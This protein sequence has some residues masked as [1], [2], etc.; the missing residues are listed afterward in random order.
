MISKSGKM[1]DDLE[2]YYSNLLEDLRV[3]LTG[4][5]P[6]D[7]NENAAI[8]FLDQNEF[9]GEK[10]SFWKK[11]VRYV[12]L[13]EATPRGLAE[14]IAL[15]GDEKTTEDETKQ[16]QELIDK[17]LLGDAELMKQMLL[18]DGAAAHDPN[19]QK[20][21]PSAQYGH[22]MEIYS[23]ILSMQN[24]KALETGY[25]YLQRL[26]LA[27]ALE[28]AIPVTQS[29][30][31]SNES[32]Y[33]RYVDPVRRYLNYEMA[34]LNGE[35]DPCSQWLTTWELRFVVD[36]D[37]P[38]E[39]AI[40]GRK[41]LK[42]FRPDHILMEN[43]A[44]RY[45]DLVKTDVKYGSENVKND[46]PELQ[47]YQNILMNGG[48]CGRRAFMGRFILRS[49][50]I[51][52]TARP[53]KGHGALIHWIPL[54]SKGDNGWTT[55]LGAGWGSGTTKT[56]YV[57]DLDFLA[58]SKARH[59][60]LIAEDSGSSYIKVKRAQWI[61]D[62][63]GEQR[64]YGESDKN[65][66]QV[67]FWYGISLKVQRAI[68]DEMEM[69]AKSSTA[70][71][72]QT[73]R[74]TRAGGW[75]NNP[76]SYG[77]DGIILIPAASAQNFKNDV[78]LMVS[79]QED[80]GKQMYL[81]SI[82]PQGLNVMRGGSW[83]AAADV[84]CS[85]SRLKSGGYGKYED[86]GFRVALTCETHH[87][88]PWLILDIGKDGSCVPLELVYIEPG[89]FEMGGES[90]EDGRFKCVEVPKHTVKITQGYYLGK[91]PVTQAQY[92]ALM[93]KNTSK[94]TKDPSCPVDNVGESNT[95]L[96]CDE[97]CE[98]TGCGIRLPTEAEWE[99]ASRAK[100]KSK[101][102]FGN[103]IS[104][105]G[106]YAWFGDNAEGKS[107]PVGQKKP[108]PWGLYDMYGN[109]YERVSDKYAKDYYSTSPEN[110]PTGPSVGTKSHFEYKISV[111][112]SGDYNLT[113][114]VVTNNYEQTLIV[115]VNNKD[116]D[117]AIPITLPFTLG[118]WGYTVPVKVHMESGENTLYFWRDNPPQCGIAIKS[119]TLK[120][121]N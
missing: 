61:G 52:T 116:P 101:W 47:Q 108:N 67:G 79:F 97:A 21:V 37:E 111:A 103:D 64:V 73:K 106:D 35:L 63:L 93:G 102:F 39:I 109:V 117:K 100:K 96:F 107:H 16:R 18:A 23:E 81:P 53:Q 90:T 112:Q 104:L 12:V 29:N 49:F 25:C 57:K 99:Y 72:K 6:N 40:W 98:R 11:L 26:A 86:W 36:G 68:L 1:I 10:S 113:A 114:S 74:E 56:C 54:G 59:C 66:D 84:C 120:P 4:L 115:C 34:Y 87:H 3:E 7:T 91:Y 105:L 85:G 71:T 8:D 83:K 121:V 31:K 22:A 78:K 50:G 92:M 69:K 41:M 65:I 43:Y 46:R 118:D 30:P 80:V 77:D 5:I 94:S 88:D 45:S 76:I 13:M 15:G 9:F 17:Q 62:V 24:V 42:N 110:D 89:T 19:K 58:T 27:I 70:V 55:N 44:W 33:G 51:P 20:K 82:S 14:F 119:F 2:K 28:H 60:S 95:K 48:V 38:D 32:D 75:K